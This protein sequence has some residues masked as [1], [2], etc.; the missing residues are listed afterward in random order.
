M[1]T[2]RS[3]LPLFVSGL[4]LFLY[5]PLFVLLVFSFNKGGFPGRW[6]GFT[7]QWYHD[8]FHE[9][10][11]WDT[12]CNSLIVAFGS[13]FLTLF[14]SIL[15]IFY[16]TLSKK[17]ERLIPLFYGNLLIP[18]T[19]LALSLLFL[20]TLVHIPLGFATLIV[21]HTLLGLG[22]VVPI[23]YG[24]LKEL[25]SSYFEA[26]ASLGA[27]AYQTFT[28]ITLPLLKPSIV[29]SSLLIF[30]LSLDD[31]IFSYFCS[32]SETQTLPLHILS[33][34]RGGM[35]PTLA[36]LTMLVVFVSMLF[37][38]LVFFFRGESYD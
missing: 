13:T 11:L 35:A 34:I 10:A 30:I 21:A 25:D 16:L 27:T 5:I 17:T 23:L 14:L 1:K 29:V 15:L 3:F 22:F 6:K 31:F 7:F 24:R 32:S 28:K 4:Y 37:G 20:I 38:L 8:L 33:M 12:F 2:A 19:F 9:V 18:E 26:S 36:P